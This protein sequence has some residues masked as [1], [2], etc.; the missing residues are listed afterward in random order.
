VGGVRRVPR[1]STETIYHASPTPVTTLAANWTIQQTTTYVEMTPAVGPGAWGGTLTDLDRVLTATGSGTTALGALIT[2]VVKPDS[3]AGVVL[4]IQPTYLSTELPFLEVWTLD[5]IVWTKRNRIALS[6][7]VRSGETLIVDLTSPVLDAAVVDAMWITLVPSGTETLT[8]LILHTYGICNADPI[9]PPCPPGTPPS[10]CDNVTCDVDPTD[11][12]CLPFPDDT[13]GCPDD[14]P[15]GAP[16]P[17]PPTDPLL[18]PPIIVP[19]AMPDTYLSFLGSVHKVLFHD[20]PAPQNITMSFGELPSGGSVTVTVQPG[21]SIQFSATN[22]G[23][24]VTSQTIAVAGDM[25]W[26]VVAGTG[27]N[28]Y[29][30]AAIPVPNYL[31]PREIT[32]TISFLFTRQLAGTVWEVAGNLLDILMYFWTTAIKYPEI[33]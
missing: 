29:P 31:P 2:W 6:S 8:W 4:K 33:C 19:I 11:W 16:G 18:L 7:R 25:E 14:C 28:A 13:G 27:Y 15:D 20:C 12:V 21:L 9:T 5:G 26:W 1:P 24:A 30:A 10:K 32:P 23:P 22:G 3:I 17:T